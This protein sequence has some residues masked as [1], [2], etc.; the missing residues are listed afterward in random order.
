[1]SLAD[2]QEAFTQALLTPF[3]DGSEFNRIPHLQDSALAALQFQALR[4]RVLAHLTL[5]LGEVYPTV[6][7]L[8]GKTL[9]KTAARDYFMEHPPEAV[10]PVSMTGQFPFF[11]AQYEAAQKTPYLT[12]LATL[13]QGYYQSGR[14]QEVSAVSTRIF[15]ELSPEQLAVRQ[16]QLHPGCYWFASPYAVY[17][18]W[19]SQQTQNKPPESYAIPQD[20][21]V[22]RPHL[23]VE[24]HKIDPGFVRTLDELDNGKS[25]GQALTLGNLVDKD[26][27]TAAAMQFLIQN[28][29]IVA[30]Y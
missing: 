24:L 28:D 5:T 21:L 17:D 19:Q 16:V 25:L 6:A 4:D 27:N 1:M 14:T 30:L 22:I 11:L 18:I 3:P 8:L 29:L 10:D 9:F 13:D 7:S 2:F 15:T 20:V 26:F 23:N 12:D